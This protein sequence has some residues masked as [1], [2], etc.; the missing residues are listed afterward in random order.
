MLRYLTAGET[1]GKCLT[2]IIEGMP[3]GV[4]IDIEKINKAL[5]YRQQGYARGGR[6]KI[7]TDK[8]EILSGVRN[9]FTMGGPIAIKIENRDWTNWEKIMDSQNAV[10]EKTVTAPRPGHADLTGGMKY[11]HRDLRNVLERASARETAARVAVGSVVMQML[12]QFGIEFFRRCVSIGSVFDESQKL[13]REFYQNARISP[14][15][16]GSEKSEK[17]AIA[18]LTDAKAKGESVGGIV[19][20][21]VKNCPPGLGSYAQYDRKLD[22]NIAFSAM[23]I[24][25]IKGVEI[26]DGFDVTKR[27]GSTVHDE[28]YYNGGVFSRKTNNAGGI[29]GGMSNGE[30]IVVRAA[31]KPI[32][33]LYSPLNTVDINTKEEKKASVERS[34]T[35]AV[36]ACSVV[37]E[38]VIGFEIGKAFLEKFGNDTMT[39][40]KNSY[41]AYIERI[42]QY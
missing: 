33:T 16:F 5:R 34:D 28:I 25:A 31:M 14:V 38:S 42:S 8:A 18:F 10:S 26:G 22:A 40:I 32:P 37:L 11:N 6:M 4:G 13:D 30:P 23:S 35:C 1:H 36:Y 19:E 15:G 9:G 39:D 41:D 29:E 20:V 3:S 27:L 21:T 7:E 17:E 12:E 2:A 24:Q